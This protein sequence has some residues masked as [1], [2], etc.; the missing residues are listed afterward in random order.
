M[1]LYKSLVGGLIIA[2]VIHTGAFAQGNTCEEQLNAATLEFEAGRFYGIPAMLKPCL[3]K[4]FSREQKKRAY[5]LLT[6]TYILLDDPIGADNSYLEVLHADP[7][8]LADTARDHIDVVY[9]S[10]RFTASP[11][12]SVFGRIGGNISPVRVINTISSSGEDENN[13]YNVRM[14]AQLALG[15]D[16]H[17]SEQLALSAEVNYMFTSFRKTQDKFNGD[18][19]QFTDRQSWVSLPVAVKYSPW[20]RGQI[21]PY[22]F[23][24]YMLSFLLT[25]RAQIDIQKADE[26]LAGV[27]E[28]SSPNMDFIEYRKRIARSFFIGGG[29]K[30]KLGIN[31]LFAEMRYNFG[32]SNIVSNTTTFGQSGPA[33]EWGY[34]DDY[35][36]LDNFSISVGYVYPLYKPRMVKRAKTKSVLKGIKKQG[37]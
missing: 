32:L 34:V 26:G 30:Y 8:F 11:I 36:R 2:C 27:I 6:Q 10:K 31:F 16:W 3:D 22:A 9:L 23:G 37:R 5:L 24:G 21:R 35:F 19:W 28:A 14:G 33:V 13:N 1:R 7:E 29:V 18:R 4:G 15:G 25:D 12:F 17:L 20:T